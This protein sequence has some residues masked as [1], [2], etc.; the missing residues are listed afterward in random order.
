MT[1]K[2]TD[3]K[4]EL[5]RTLS[6]A[7]TVQ[8]IIKS[9]SLTEDLK[10]IL[11]EIEHDKLFILTDEHTMKLC[12]PLLTSILEID[13][14][15]KIVI[16]AGDINKTL[17]NL[18]H[19][20]KQ[21]TTNGAT[22]HSLLINL[23]GGMVTDI[24]GFAAATFKRGVSY[25]NIPTTLLGA[26]DAAVGGKTGINFEGYKNEIGAF[27]PAN[28]VLISSD[29]F[30]TLSVK[31]VLSGY[32]EMLKHALIDSYTEW[33]KIKSIDLENVSYD[34]LKEAL[35]R[36]IAIKQNIVEQDPFEQN[37][38]KALNLGH[39]IGHAF[40]SFAIETENPVLHGYAVAWGMI[41]ELYLAY[42]IC[43]FPKET[44]IEASQYIHQ[45]YGA[46][47]I[48]CDDYENLYAYMLHDKKNEG[49]LIN[50]T[51]LSDVGKI[52]INQNATKDMIFE[53]LDFYRDSVGL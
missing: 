37:I 44:L 5:T 12:L 2:S 17:E 52:M 26:V 18:T 27:Y 43:G 35:F 42:K 46:F 13:K 41:A 33:N 24:G 50:F 23:G 3:N 6:V 7:P 40:E 11:S 48:K 49:Q 53:A 1:T 31:D 19:I 21:L 34:N 9:Y 15:P 28:H 45:L 4:T 47:D 29:F 14:A 38:R 36:S 32:A 25:I 22:R 8:Q 30:L 16:P 20:W 10:K 39:T 51:L